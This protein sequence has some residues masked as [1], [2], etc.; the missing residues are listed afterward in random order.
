MKKYLIE[1]KTSLKSYARVMSF[2]MK[3][4]NKQQII[5]QFGDDYYIIDINET[6]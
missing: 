2:Y 3:A 6:E 4:Y 5:D 1:I